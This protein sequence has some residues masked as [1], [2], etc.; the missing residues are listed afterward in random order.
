[1]RGR[2]SVCRLS[3]GRMG[4]QMRSSGTPTA[5]PAKFVDRTTRCSFCGKRKGK[6][7][8]LIAGPGV[9]ICNDCVALCQDILSSQVPRRRPWWR[10][11]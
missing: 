7:E 11:R 8:K 6:C 1:M 2:S 3:I 4:G 5:A 10:S 9:Y